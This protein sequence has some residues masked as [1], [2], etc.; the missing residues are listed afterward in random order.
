MFVINV[1][2]NRP[3]LVGF[4]AVALVLILVFILSPKSND[5]PTT[6]N[7]EEVSHNIKRR[8]KE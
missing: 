2:K 5:S 1:I 8:N 4:M 7:N 6:T 3:V